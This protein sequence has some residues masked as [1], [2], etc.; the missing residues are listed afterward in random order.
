MIGERMSPT[1]QIAPRWTREEANRWSAGEPWLCGFNYIPATAINYTEMWQG[2][3]FDAA[4]IAQELRLA[5]D[6]GFNCLRV[7]LQYMVW[8][9]DPD[10]L[11]RRLD[12]FLELCIRHGLRAAICLFDD[13]AFGDLKDP[14]LGKQPEVIQGWYA[15]GW[16]PSPG[17]GLVRD[18]AA[19]PDLGL[20]VRDIIGAFRTDGRVFLWDP[21]NEPTNGI[22]DASLPLLE[23]VILQA[24]QADP[25]QPITV[26]R[27]N[28]HEALN[29]LA[30][31]ASDITTFHRYGS[32]QELEKMIL[33][34]QNL[35][36][37]VLCTEWLKRDLGDVESQLAVL[38]KYRVGCLHWGLVNGKT[39]THYPWGSRPPAQEPKVWQHDIFRPDHTAYDP[40]EI[41]AFR[42]AIARGKVSQAGKAVALKDGPNVGDR[43]ESQA[44]CEE[45]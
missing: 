27:W 43:F 13:C 39:Q 25:I 14:H 28:D 35:G 17:W 33:Q 7:V 36:R 16:A 15:N 31:N 11:K 21:Y 32:A 9:D 20:Y 40:K 2:E 6:V 3:T 18:R 4:S 5:R 26:G 45:L 1:A 10:G 37:P 8:R 12:A 42:T 34:L 19:W 23:Q 38:G 30:M 41:E 22:G 24:R 44:S 29:A